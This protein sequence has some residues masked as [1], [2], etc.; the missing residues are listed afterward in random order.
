MASV[1]VPKSDQLNA[2]DLI[3]GPRT[4]TITAVSIRDAAEQPVSISYEGDGGKPYKPCK[5]MCRVM[6]YAWG[7]DAKTYVGRSMTLYRDPKVKW[8]GLEVGGIRISHMSH[9]EQDR[10]MTLTETRGVIKPY[11]VRSL[12]A[13]PPPATRAAMSPREPDGP[14]ATP[15]V[16]ERSE[17][18]RELDEAMKRDWTKDLLDTEGGMMAEALRAATSAEEVD[19]KWATFADTIITMPPAYQQRLSNIR[20][21]MRERLPE[22]PA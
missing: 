5:S 13:T 8:G 18:D 15:A 19:S 9:I 16:G 12:A 7:K 14:Q 3:S 10:R 4:V 22:P 11:M 2:D 21:E 17:F 6:V 1:I 20:N